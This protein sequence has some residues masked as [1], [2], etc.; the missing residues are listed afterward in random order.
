MPV[1][2]TPPRRAGARKKEK[3]RSI[4]IGMASAN[5]ETTEVSESYEFKPQKYSSTYLKS[6]RKDYN[7]IKGY[8]LLNIPMDVMQAIDQSIIKVEVEDCIHVSKVD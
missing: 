3:S 1:L 5:V 6:S 2:Y 7:R 8:V 4:N